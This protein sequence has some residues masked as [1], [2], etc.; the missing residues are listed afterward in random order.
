MVKICALVLQ[1]L[2][3]VPAFALD[4][5][6]SEIRGKSSKE[7]VTVLQN[8]YFLKAFRPEF[9]LVSGFILDEAYLNTTTFGARSGM[10]FTEWFGFELQSFRTRVADSDDRK[11]LRKKQYAP[12]PDVDDNGNAIP[13]NN[14]DGT[15][16][17]VTPDPEVNAIHSITDVSGVAAPFYG[18]LNVLNKW[19]IYTDLY[20]SAGA[21]IIETDQG[22]KNAINISVGERF[23]IGKA[24]SFRVDGR[25]RIYT[26]E[27]A[28][29]KVRK[30]SYGF[31]FGASYFF[32]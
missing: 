23:Y 5:S 7:P 25:D 31:D 17:T 6:A 18:K 10:F 15:I 19:I 4:L 8:R 27:R 13:A 20:V 14:P 21:S 22:R 30:N 3:V 1:A 24:W 32:N 28:G 2:V 16:V 12:L 9:G 29:D 26:E 11:A